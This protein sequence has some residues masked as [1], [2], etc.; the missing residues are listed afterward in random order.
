MLK[1]GRDQQNIHE[2]EPRKWTDVQ[3]FETEFDVKF[4]FFRSFFAYPALIVLF[5]MVKSDFWVFNTFLRHVYSAFERCALGSRFFNS[6][7]PHGYRLLLAVVLNP[8]RLRVEKLVPS[9]LQPRALLHCWIFPCNR[10]IF[11]RQR[12]LRS[13]DVNRMLMNL[14]KS[15]GSGCKVSNH[16]LIPSLFLDSPHTIVNHLRPI[17]PRFCIF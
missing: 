13:D 12:N 2:F 17:E 6:P 8:Q 5:L 15:L 16:I 3:P 11:H 9:T 14:N 1:V 7:P 4:L 10:L